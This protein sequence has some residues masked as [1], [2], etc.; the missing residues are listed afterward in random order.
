M[1]PSFITSPQGRLALYE[2]GTG[3]GLPVLFLHADS[4]VAGQWAEVLPVI[5][6][7]RPVIALD[8]RGSGASAE[9]TDGDYSY[10]GRARDIAAV[11]EAKKLER[12]VIV[13]HSGSGA[14]ALRYAA[15]NPQR[16]AGLFLLDPATDPRVIPKD[17]RDGIVTGLAGPQ[18]LDFQKQFYATIAGPDA[19]VQARVLSDCEKVA[20][21]ARLGFGKAFAE[22][23]PVVDLDA[24][25]GPIFILAGEAS[26]N[27]GAL[28]RLRPAIP[29]EVVK[30]TGHWL[31]LDAPDIV[32]TAIRRFIAGIE[33]K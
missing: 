7:D 27:P 8:T 25:K 19:K 22:W 15:R 28:Y 29:N 1:T 9:A 6:A 11:A 4:G 16:V 30:G 17:I 21:K 18:S 5:A 26:D 12:F 14:A 24:W 23:N 2:Q 20:Q 10:D 13:A 33:K 31:Q 32:A 3:Q